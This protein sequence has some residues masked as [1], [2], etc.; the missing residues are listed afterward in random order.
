ME[1]R[2]ARLEEGNL[3]TEITMK[4]K[5]YWGYDKSFIEACREA[6]MLT[7]REVPL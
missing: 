1:V 7:L 4:S 3:L 6:I 5:A 2:K